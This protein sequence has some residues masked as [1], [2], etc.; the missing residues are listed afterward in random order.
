MPPKNKNNDKE[1]RLPKVSYVDFKAIDIDRVL[2]NL[3]PRLKFNGRG[4]R[5]KN[6]NYEI[7]TFVDEFL[8]E[9]QRGRFRGFEQYPEV[10]KKWVETDLLDL[11]NRGRPKQ[12]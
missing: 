6:N 10:V 9:E 5:I 1:F 4:G 11:V 2:L 12:A 3:F 8:S 7:K